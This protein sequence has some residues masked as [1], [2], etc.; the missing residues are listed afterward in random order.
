MN[1]ARASED[2]HEKLEPAAFREIDGRELAR[3]YVAHR[4]MMQA[5]AL[6]PLPGHVG[7]NSPGPRSVAQDEEVPSPSR[8]AAFHQR[9]LAWFLGLWRA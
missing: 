2:I 6:G 7:D 1:A 8:P 5:E 4:S 3:Q 9:F